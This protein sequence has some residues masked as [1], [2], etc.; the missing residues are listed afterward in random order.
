MISRQLGWFAMAAAVVGIGFAIPIYT[1]A[2]ELSNPG[3][4]LPDAS[5]GD[6]NTISGWNMFNDPNLSWVTQTTPAHSGL[7]SLKMFGPW[8]VWGGVGGTQ[9]FPAAIGDVWAAEIWS[10]NDRSDPM[11]AGNFAAMKIEFLDHMSGPAGGSW[12][13]D[14]NVFEIIVANEFSPQDTWECFSLISA[15]APADTSYAQYVLVEVQGDPIS[16]GS[17]FLDD[18]NF[19][20]IPEPGTLGLVVSGFLLVVK[21]ALL[22]RR[23]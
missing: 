19:Y 20:R 17:V 12:L 15:P 5:E 23:F 21:V 6:V 2:N 13:A 14:I 9:A 18:G 7:Q 4:E 3:F 1:M 8:D 10:R 22:R 16:G 11:G